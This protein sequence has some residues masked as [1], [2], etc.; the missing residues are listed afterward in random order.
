MA[1]ANSKNSTP[2][3]EAAAEKNEM[4]PKRIQL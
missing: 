1:M 3:E 4:K 2:R